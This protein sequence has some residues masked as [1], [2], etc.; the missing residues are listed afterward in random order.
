MS[1][2]EYVVG[3]DV[4]TSGTKAVLCGLDGA[5][6]GSA[7][8]PHSLTQRGNGRIEQ[9][10]AALLGAVFTATSHLLRN[11]GADS[12]EVLAIGL[13]GQMF[14]TIAVD[15]SGSAITPLLSW[16]DTRAT[17]QAQWISELHT[18]AQQ[19]ARYGSV[20][21]AK[22]IVPKVMWLQ[23]EVPEVATRAA[24][25]LDCKDF[26]GAGLTGQIATDLHGASAYYLFGIES[27]AWD[28][29]AAE[30]LGLNPKQLPTV[31]HAT[32]L[33]GELI[34]D[35]ARRSGLAPGTP[36]MVGTGDVAA[37]QIGAGSA[38]GGQSHLSL[39]TASYFGISLDEV[40]RDPNQRLGLLCHVDPARWL[41]WAEMETGGG[42]LA[43]WRQ[44]V[45][46]RA[47]D[48]LDALASK[49]T[50]E[51]ADLL[52]APWLTGERVPYWD[53]KARG[54][55]VGLRM[56]HGLP[57]LSRAVLEGI[58]YQLRLVLEY[59]EAFGTQAPA[60]RVIGGGSVGRLLPQIIADV[61]ARPL[62]VV[63]ASQDAGA[64]GAA[65]VAL[66]ARGEASIDDLAASVA[67]DRVVEV[68]ASRALRDLYDERF[69]GF[70]QLHGALE[71]PLQHLT[72][73]E[74]V[75]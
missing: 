60:I 28:Q 15:E 51:E 40:H 73:A 20:L 68:T 37:G 75:L 11:S 72:A 64:R 18:P 49:V 31:R 42:A 25:F 13:S 74:T 61:L 66:A 59:A 10:G 50:A 45:G 4:G 21:T 5:V 38:R 1:R 34:T 29:P 56:H 62:E 52:F 46:L 43:W 7:Y 9:D 12:N 39:G 23:D 48:G 47:P 14:N 17:R 24:A 70:R 67:V 35:A 27:R 26:V 8:E 55:F 36:V 57:H 22:D 32:D 69:A 71:L 2:R 54:A 3:Y 58:A 53:D 44:L 16:L 63:A 41:L 65:F 6:H 19:F 30:E 33:L